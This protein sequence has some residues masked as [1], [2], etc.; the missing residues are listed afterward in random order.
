MANNGRRQADEQYMLLHRIYTSTLVYGVLLITYGYMNR[1]FSNG[2]A[3]L[4]QYE[5]ILFY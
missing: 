5:F 1:F 3:Y 2:V 4:Y